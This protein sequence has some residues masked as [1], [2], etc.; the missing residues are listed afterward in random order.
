MLPLFLCWMPVIFW[1]SRN[2]TAAAGRLVS[3]NHQTYRKRQNNRRIPG[4][5]GGSIDPRAVPRSHTILESL[6]VRSCSR[7]LIKRMHFRP[8]WNLSQT[9]LP[10]V[11]SWRWLGFLPKFC[12]RR[13]GV[14]EALVFLAQTRTHIGCRRRKRE[15]LS[16]ALQRKI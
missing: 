10:R 3:E 11:I 13:P 16:E 9:Q 6:G 5:K 7:F 15:R 1:Q 8:T 2:F 4:H 14:S 12:R